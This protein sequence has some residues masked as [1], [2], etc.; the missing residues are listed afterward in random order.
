MNYEEKAKALL[1]CSAMCHRKFKDSDEMIHMETCPAPYR[2]DVAA[3]LKEAWDA[4]YKASEEEP[5]SA[6][7]FDRMLVKSA[8]NKE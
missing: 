6:Q 1:P 4:G 5:I 7:Q 3:A 2:P 8:K